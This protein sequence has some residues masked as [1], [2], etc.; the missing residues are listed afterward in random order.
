MIRQ[1]CPNFYTKKKYKYV[2]YQSDLYNTQ[3]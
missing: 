1:L 3:L 2:A